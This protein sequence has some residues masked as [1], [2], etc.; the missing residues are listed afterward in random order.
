MKAMPRYLCHGFD[1]EGDAVGQDDHVLVASQL[2]E[3]EGAVE[4]TVLGLRGNDVGEAS[5]GEDFGEASWGEE[6]QH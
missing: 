1:L 6:G 5:R 3:E 2:V 4:D